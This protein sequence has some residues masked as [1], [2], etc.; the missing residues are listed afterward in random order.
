MAANLHIKKHIRKK[1]H[2]RIWARVQMRASHKKNTLP[3]RLCLEEELTCRK[4]RQ[5]R[6][7]GKRMVAREIPMYNLEEHSI[8][9][10]DNYLNIDTL[11]MLSNRSSGVTATIYTRQLVC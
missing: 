9:L 2:A 1:T 7:E 5:V 11:T 3:L 10:I 4:F 8:I 6:K